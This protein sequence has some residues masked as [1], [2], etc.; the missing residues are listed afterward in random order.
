M[1]RRRRIPRSRGKVSER[2][3]LDTNLLLVVVVGSHAPLYVSKHERTTDYTPDDFYRLER[4]IRF[5]AA[6]VTTPHILTEVSNLLGQTAGP[7]RDRY[8]AAFSRVI[9]LFEEVHVP[10]RQIST[11]PHFD[12]F[13][14]TDLGIVEAANPGTSVLTSDSR[15]ADYLYR[16]TVDVTFY[17]PSKQ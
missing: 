1:T 7:V 11:R 17:I 10:A 12:Q 6:M 3:L 14:L 16:S 9:R 15:L 2:I 8:F 4:V 13:G 5:S